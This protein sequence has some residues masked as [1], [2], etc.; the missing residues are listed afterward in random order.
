MSISI[1]VPVLN[2]AADIQ[3]TLC[4]LRHA[5]NA[6]DQ[7][8]VVDGGS[9]DDTC[10]LAEA[11]C[12]QVVVS[13]KGRARQLNAGAA[14]AVHSILW[15]VHADTAVPA[16]SASI[17]ARALKN[18]PSW[19]RFN[20]KFTS[21]KAAFSVIAFFINWR[22]RLTGVATGDQA[23][24][25]SRELFDS[26]NGFPD[27]PLMEDVDISKALKRHQPPVCLKERVTTS[28]RR[29]EKNGVLRTVLLMWKLRLLHFLGVPAS[30]LAEQYRN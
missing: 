22:S 6:D 26:V 21:P 28:S 2:E 20:V 4:N 7:I 23:I 16:N 5:C 29:W 11:L 12:N 8:I 30:R 19:G 10:T 9:S 1:I 13:E 24:F 25:I 27:L 14:V 18:T 17:V 15:F 3:N